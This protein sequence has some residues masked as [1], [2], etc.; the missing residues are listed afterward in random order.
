M[1]QQIVEGDLIPVGKVWHILGNAIGHAEASLFL[2]LQNRRGRERLVDRGDVVARLVGVRTAQ[3][4]VRHSITL[5]K[6]NAATAR[7]KNSTA[8]VSALGKRSEIRTHA[9]CYVAVVH[10]LSR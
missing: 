1:R 4:I 10:G 6:Q 8:K 3:L 9:A 2:E 7:N 5:S